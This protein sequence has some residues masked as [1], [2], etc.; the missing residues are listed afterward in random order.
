MGKFLDT[1]SK[2]Y[3][4]LG[5]EAIHALKGKLPL[6]EVNTGAVAR[7]Y[8]TTP[9]P[10]MDFLKEFQR[11]GFGAV[12]TSD[13]HDRNYLDCFYDESRELLREAGFKSKFVF[14]SNG[15][16]EVAL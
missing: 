12:I 14:T 4:D 7:G 6:F 1:D 16:E 9:Y 15:F 3:K 5:F 10:Q 13:C 11:N 2:E 8:R